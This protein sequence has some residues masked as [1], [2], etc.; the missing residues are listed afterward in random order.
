MWVRLPPPGPTGNKNVF[1]LLIYICVLFGML[2]SIF[3]KHDLFT[4]KGFI[5][6]GILNL[7]FLIGNILSKYIYNKLG[8]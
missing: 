4:L 8:G 3:I 5:Q 1:S 2:T 6:W 7:L